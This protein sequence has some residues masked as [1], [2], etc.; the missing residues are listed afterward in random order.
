MKSSADKKPAEP[1]GA[2][3]ADGLRPDGES[4]VA[5]FLWGLT[6]LAF[7]AA[8]IALAYWTGRPKPLKLDVSGVGG[9]GQNEDLNIDRIR[10]SVRALA[11]PVSRVTGYPGNETA[12]RYVLDSLTAAGITDTYTQEFQVA[13]PYVESATLTAR[14]ASGPVVIR[15]H[16]LWPNLARTSQTPENG[17]TGPL[18]DLGKGSDADLAGKE[19]RGAVA[20]MD[21]DSRNEWL[22]VPEFGGKAVLF[23]ADPAA[24]GSSARSKFLTVPANVPRFYVAAPDLP[25]FDRLLSIP[26]LP[27]TIRCKMF[28]K[29]ATAKNLLARVPG[30]DSKGG[31]GEPIIFHAYYDSISVTPDLAPGAEQAC[32]AATLLELARYFR[33]KG[34][35]HPVYVLFTGAHG[36]AFEG[37]IHFVRLLRDGL[38]HGW[39]KALRSSLPARMGRPALFVGLDLSSHSDRFG[40]F[41]CGRFR[42]QYEGRLRPQFSTLGLKLDQF[43][44]AN[45]PNRNDAVETSQFVDCI[46]LTLG[47]GWW[48]YFPYQAPFESEIPT[49]A[50]LP[51]ITLSTIND[52]R[53]AV[54]TPN[55]TIDR[56]D[57]ETLGRQLRHVPGKR[58]G[59][60][61]IAL[62]L[63]MWQGPYVSNISQM[64]DRLARLDGRVVWLDQERDYTANQP[65]SR[66]VVFLKTQR[67]DK[68]L[69]GTRGAPV[70]LTD[71]KGHFQFDGLIQSLANGQFDNC[72]IEAYGLATG[73]F[74]AAN[75]RAVSQYYKVLKARGAHPDLKEDGAVFYAVDMARAK[76]YP[77]QIKLRKL[78]QSLNLV[79]FPCK[80][81]T[82][83]GLTDPREYM[84]LKDVQIL[85]AATESPPFEFGHSATDQFWGNPEEN[86]TTVWGDP[87]LN[88]RI[89]LGFGFQKKRLILINNS[90][91]NPIGVGFKLD[92]L[93]GIPSMV[94]Q[95][96]NDM[97]TLDDSRLRKLREQGIGNP[98]IE[99][100]H[101]EAREKLDAAQ[102]ALAARDYRTYRSM[103]ENGWA[104][105][106]KAYG[107]LLSTTNNM[108]R[109]VLFYLLLLLPFSYCLERLLFASGTIRRRLI[110]MISIFAASFAVL[111]A[112]HPAF[113]FTL[114]PLIVLL[115][116]VILALAGTVTA[117]ILGKFDAALRERKQQLTGFHEESSRVGNIAVRAVDL[118][119]ANIRRRKQRG[120]LT[121]MTIVAVTFTL[122]SFVSIVP[123]LNISRLKH[124]DGV[125]DAGRLLARDR[126]WAPMR[127][128]AFESLRRTFAAGEG[129]G[130]GN[131]GGPGLVLFGLLGQSFPNRLERGRKEAGRR[132][133]PFVG[134]DRKSIRGLHRRRPALH[135]GVGTGSQPC[136]AYSDRRPLVPR[137]R[138]TRHHTPPPHCRLPGPRSRRHRRPDIGLRGE[139]PLDRHFRREG[140]RPNPRHRRRA[141]DPGQ[142]RSPTADDGRT[143]LD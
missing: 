89:T 100:L 125:P 75:P 87:T 19:L 117:L 4:G 106:G 79:C 7:I 114:T 13:V 71:E 133:S 44:K 8:T 80:S 45:A 68:Y 17:I 14:T 26:G 139:T 97:W 118:G 86:C 112:V 41:C 28:W 62:A 58:I 6:A 49:T 31:G 136:G 65:L 63:A 56:V 98:R 5:R 18:V 39:P 142:F 110:G 2:S 40:V 121:G 134:L 95:G 52:A 46:N 15:L 22:A 24:D 113:R 129:A 64:T 32:G 27:V 143:G 42:G 119:I 130:S 83:Y 111:A 25:T 3:V 82:L 60:A 115:A 116:F 120:I 123:E 92:E 138:R 84:D 70:V 55:D 34:T 74:I 1:D 72:L 20:V 140:I 93:D 108:I 35:D 59:L 61:N 132:P 38:D 10:A 54:D 67:G 30:D 51:G 101:A 99:K 104:L 90:P 48:T 47:R 21:W 103:A 78:E 50:V 81:V 96:G 91:E 105:E 135:G 141:V 12:F 107:E 29:R 69:C 33:G 131:N 23:R 94:L 53:R 43:A 88:V 16:P 76:E 137:Q 57:F 77:W 11:A 126:R 9:A 124:P 122:L 37:M 66:A 36:Q 128:P 85:D 109:G 127:F 73:P 102:Q